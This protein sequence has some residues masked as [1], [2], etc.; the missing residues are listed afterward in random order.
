V[1]RSRDIPVDG[2]GN[3]VFQKG[4]LDS[5]YEATGWEADPYF[6]DNISKP[7]SH[8]LGQLYYDTCTLSTDSN[9]FIIQTMGVDHVVFGTDY[10]FDIGDPEG[11]RS[12]PVIDSRPEADRAK[13]YKSNAE[14][15][16]A[17]GWSGAKA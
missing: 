15:L 10:P 13:I 14:S 1:S 7:P 11:R 4:R 6:T 9:R 16:L 8:Y 12:V 2:G 5:A 17:R 3:L